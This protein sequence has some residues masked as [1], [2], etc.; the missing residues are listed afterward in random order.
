MLPASKRRTPKSMDDLSAKEFCIFRR[1]NPYRNEQDP[2]LVNRPFWTKHQRSIY[3]DVLKGKKNLFVSVRSI[4]LAHLRKDPKY[5][6]EALAMCEQLD[7]LRIMSF[8]KDFDAEIVAQFYATVHLGTD[9]ERTLTWMTN[10]RVLS[11]KWKDFMASLGYDDQGLENPVGLRP[12]KEVAA[13]HKSM[14]WPY[15]T[16][17]VSPTTGKKSYEL[18]PFLDI[19][20]RIFRNTL[21]PRIGNLDQVHSYLVDMLLICEKE[22]N[23]E[24]VLDVS[25]VMWSELHSAV[26]ERKCP[27]YGPY[28]MLLIENTW[29]STFPDEMFVSS[30]LVSA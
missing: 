30:D 3:L 22:K 10:G 18:C 7:I 5:F 8:N 24:Q 14:L 20:H 17:K 6:G 12:H 21:F 1:R 15:S 29:A 25:H 19:M 9:D 16:E 26:M 2:S 4:D 13:S 23:T 28:L 27:I 11:A